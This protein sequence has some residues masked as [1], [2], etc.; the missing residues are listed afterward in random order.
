MYLRRMKGEKIMRKYILGIFII[1]F[2]IILASCANEKKSISDESDKGKDYPYA[3]SASTDF[4]SPS[5]DG[6]Y[7]LNGNFIYY[8]D[9]EGTPVLLDNRPNHE[10]LGP[11]SETNCNAYVPFSFQSTLFQFYEGSLYTIENKDYYPGE[12]DWMESV[13]F[14]LVKRSPDGAS[15]QVIT[16]FPASIIQSAVIHRDFLYYDISYYDEDNNY[17]YELQRLPI[18]NPKKEAETIYEGQYERGLFSITP[19]GSNIYITDLSFIKEDK[20]RFDL[21]TE[22]IIS[23]LEEDDDVV[24]NVM[25]FYQDKMYLNKFPGASL[26][27][28]ETEQTEMDKWKTVYVA[29]LE[30]K[31]EREYSLKPSYFLSGFYKDDRYTYLQA[32]SY[33]NEE[34]GIDAPKEMQIY[35]DEKLIHTVSMDDYGDFPTIVNGDERYMFMYFYLYEDELSEDFNKSFIYILDKNDIESGE[36]K[37]KELIETPHILD[38]NFD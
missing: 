34:M 25:R 1:S 32:N 27:N 18:N 26:F 19:Y 21:T 12:E 14:E 30:G 4:V 35:Q 2:V 16:S 8:M 6:Y 33:F 22:E 31:N 37:F 36:A 3:F 9:L 29:D 38:E 15:R 11:N 23:I 17:S 5:E 28:E 10:C 7:F 20:L 24:A 13:E